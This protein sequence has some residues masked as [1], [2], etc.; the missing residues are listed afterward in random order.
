MARRIRIAIM[1]SLSKSAG[2]TSKVFDGASLVKKRSE[3]KVQQIQRKKTLNKCILSDY[4]YKAEE[5]T[6]SEATTVQPL[7]NGRRMHLDGWI[8]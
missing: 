3:G 6:H 1:N 8:E 4:Q 5:G 7:E 2:S